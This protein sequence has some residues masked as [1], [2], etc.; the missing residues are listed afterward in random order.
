MAN[1]RIPELLHIPA[2]KRFVSIEP[3]IGPVD[4]TSIKGN[5]GSFYQVLKPIENCKDSNRPALDWVIC[6]CESGPNRR[7]FE[8]DWA[9]SLR[10]QCVRAGVPFFF[11]QRYI[12]SKKISLPTIDNVVWNQMPDR[13]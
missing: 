1:E 6:G 2:A 7:P 10:D 12:G 11:K 3:Q 8:F 5:A 4:L 9:V 13:I